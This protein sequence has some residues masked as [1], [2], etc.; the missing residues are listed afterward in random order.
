[1]FKVDDRRYADDTNE[2]L[3]L[4]WRRRDVA[5]SGSA[6]APQTD[7]IDELLTMRERLELAC[8]VDGSSA[9]DTAS[10]FHCQPVE[11]ENLLR[12]AA[13]WLLRIDKMFAKRC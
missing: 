9:A 2:R 6:A 10:K 11:V 8:Y 13:R 4:R 5:R 3:P 12:D 7:A 1:M